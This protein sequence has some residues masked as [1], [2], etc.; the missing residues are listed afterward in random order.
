MDDA[1]IGLIAKASGGDQRAFEALVEAHKDMVYTIA[2]RTLGNAEDAMD[3][4]QETFVSAYRNIS[5][6]RGD[7]KFSTWLCRIA[8]NRSR[9]MLSS[10]RAKGDPASI[11]EEGFDV[12]AP[13]TGQEAASTIEE[14]LELIQPDYKTAI[15]LHCLMGYSYDEAGGIMGIPGGTV[16]TY[17]H[18]GKDELRGVLARAG[19][20]L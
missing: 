4:L 3:A 11:H 14:A 8:I 12:A 6:F 9:D 16:K 17:V 18:R 7:S 19:V 15:S 20:E 10:R 13:S 1:E 2:Y 5:R